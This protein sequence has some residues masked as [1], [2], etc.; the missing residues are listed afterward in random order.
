[1]GVYEYDTGIILLHLDQAADLF[2]FDWGAATS[3]QARVPDPWQMTELT[4]EVRDALPACR[5]I[6]WQEAK[7]VLF[8]ALRVEKNLM[9]FLLTIIVVVASF[10]ITATLIT[11]VVH[12]TREIGIMKAVGMGR[13]LIARI[14]LIQG[15][16]IG[17]MGTTFGVVAGLLTVRYRN[18]LAGLIARVMGV[19]I[20]PK[21]LYHLS[22]IPG[23]ATPRDIVVIVCLALTICVMA[24]VI[25]A[26]YA[27][28]LSPARALQEE[29]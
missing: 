7:R 16:I 6:T 20:F 22:R 23:Y 2:G 8:G 4:Q 21:S 13:L 9:F 10:C 15:A 27:G 12:K 28:L 3:I 29:N 26:V 24:S 14:F 5:I 17:T 18:G 1:M 11:V 25:P 19:E